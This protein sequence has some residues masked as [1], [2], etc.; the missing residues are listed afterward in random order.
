MT[1]QIG[2]RSLQV[3]L[4]IGPRAGSPMASVSQDAASLIYCPANSTE[5]TTTMTVAGFGGGNPA[6]LWLCQ[7][8]SGNLADSIGSNALT[9]AGAPSYQQTETGWSR[10]SV[11]ITATT[12]QA[13]TAAAGVLDPSAASV[14]WLGYVCLAATPGGNR[15]VLTLTNNATGCRVDHLVA[16][17]MM[18]VCGGNTTSTANSYTGTTL[19]PILVVYNRTASSCTLYTNLESKTATFVSVVDGTKGLGAVQGSGDPSAHWVYLTAF[20]GAAA[21]A[22]NTNNARTLLQTLGWTVSF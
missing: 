15:N 19:F 20:S 10:K 18:I 1:L 13:F 12:V 21:E 3:G 7:E 14:A 5:W 9:V 17:T 2:T 8:A 4:A 6:S 16:N 22:L 11:R